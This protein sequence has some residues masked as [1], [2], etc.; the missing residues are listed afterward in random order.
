M[1]GER[2]TPDSTTGDILDLIPA[3]RLLAR[4]FMQDSDE[5]DDLVQETLVRALANLSGFRPG[6]NLRAW[7]FTIMRNA[8]LTHAP[9]RAREAPAER[10]CASVVP[11]NPP[12]HDVQIT[13]ARLME[14]IRRVPMPYREAL[15]LVFLMEESYEAAATISKCPLGTIKS[16]VSRARAMIMADL[17]AET[18]TELID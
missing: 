1:P 2:G 15:I 12:V 16:R 8:F 6:T 13:C 18:A 7:L 14:A 4:S 9:R 11:S 3:L 5:A 17:R 10:H